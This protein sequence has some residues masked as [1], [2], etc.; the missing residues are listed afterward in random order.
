MNKLLPIIL[1][2]LLLICCGVLSIAM[3]FIGQYNSLIDAN[4]NVNNQQAQIEVQL[5]RRYD[6]IPNLVESTKGF[7]NQ[8]QEVF[9]AI[10]KARA[11]YDGAPNGTNEKIEAS[12]QLESALSR[13]LVIVEAYPELK[14]DATVKQLM[15]ELAGTENRIAV[16]RS[17][18]ND[19]ATAFNK[20]I[21][22]FPTVLFANMMGLKEKQ[23]FVSVDGAN[24]APRVDLSN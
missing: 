14:S 20:R 2:F 17:R 9:S 1:G 4:E 3:Y 21:K 5:Q 19:T 13:L 10:A 6:L 18:Y 22:S 8:E 11:A 7:L 16:E 12:N 23:L 15:D 24:E